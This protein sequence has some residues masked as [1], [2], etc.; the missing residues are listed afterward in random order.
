MSTFMSPERPAKRVRQACEPC[1]RKKSKCPGEKPACSHCLR[2]GQQ[3][4][5]SNGYSND[6]PVNDRRYSETT[7]VNVAHRGSTGLPNEA[8]FTEG[9][10]G[11]RLSSLEGKV[12]EVL[13]VLNRIPFSA[14]LPS[15][16][17]S[18]NVTSARN[19]LERSPQAANSL[20]PPWESVIVVAES[21]LTYCNCQPL[22]LFDQGHFLS[23]LSG[24][25]PELLFSV[26][27]LAGR[28]S[29]EPIFQR[30]RDSVINGFAD[31]ARDVV[32]RR[33]SQ[34]P[35]ELSTLQS[36]CILSL[37]DFSN[38]NTHRASIYSTLAQDLAQC[39]GMATE[40]HAPLH[41][42]VHE[43]RRRCFWSICLLKRLHGSAT[44]L[45]A[46]E[47]VPQY[48][49]SPERPAI[50]SSESSPSP[51]AGARTPADTPVDMGI[52]AYCVS[53]SDFWC[54]AV[55]YARRRAN[56]G[57]HPPWSAR[58]EYSKIKV[59]L[60]DFE[61]RMPYKH[62]FRPAR[63]GDYSPE[64][65]Q[66][67]RGY[68]APWLLQQIIYHAV[69]CLLNHPLLLSLRLR[70]FRG[71]IPEIFLQHTA[72]LITT[73]SDWIAHFIDLLNTK[74][75]DASDPFLGHCVAI[76]GTIFLQKCFTDDDEV[77]KSKREDFIKCLTFL[78]KMGEKWPHIQIIARKLEQFEETVAASH[79]DSAATPNSNTPQQSVFIDLTLFWEI[80]ESVLTSES[81]DASGS[82]FGSSL[83]PHRRAYVAGASEVVS[84]RLLPDPTPVGDGVAIN[85]SKR[86]DVT[87]DPFASAELLGQ[88]GLAGDDQEMAVL[89]QSYFAQGQDFVRGIDDLWNIG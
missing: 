16:S 76:V 72:F 75:F 71:V 32:M 1:R 23:S 24:R 78:R 43:E 8:S 81:A 41:D 58:S 38:G 64:D 26:L 47:Q 62:R 55:R 46:D 25:D 21:Y 14:S 29:D 77:R 35:V 36:L 49:S 28:F 59:E 17:P 74:S 34:G 27:A 85:R 11:D 56:P 22:P 61:A 33:V 82:L 54:K 3:C 52:L 13:G 68:W 79:R 57:T 89:A 10:W 63:F 15:P 48:P 88:F 39:A 51:A 5:Y 31:T 12:A 19:V 42:P 18:S 7:E 45:A 73:H 2:L 87:A 60:M 9:Q 6:H 53:L 50:S 65:L 40:C 80:L 70:N 69:I 83:W 86:R 20:L 4:I 37:V 84:T 67:N 44:L 66:A 30:N